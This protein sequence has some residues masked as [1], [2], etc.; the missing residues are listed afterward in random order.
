MGRQDNKESLVRAAMEAVDRAAFVA[1]E[2]K[3]AAG[4]DRPPWLD[5]LSKFIQ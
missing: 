1:D 5:F 4:E 3:W 2:W